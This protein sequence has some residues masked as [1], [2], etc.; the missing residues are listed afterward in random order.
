MVSVRTA[1]HFH[2]GLLY[3]HKYYYYSSRYPSEMIGLPWELAGC[4][5]PELLL[6]CYN[7]RPSNSSQAAFYGLL[8]IWAGHGDSSGDS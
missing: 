7:M 1:F 5:L 8:L 2:Q 3:W 6:C 4:C